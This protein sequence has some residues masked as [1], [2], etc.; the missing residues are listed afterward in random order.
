MNFDEAY[1]Q[2]LDACLEEFNER[3]GQSRKYHQESDIPKNY[4]PGDFVEFGEDG[5]AYPHGIGGTN[6]IP[7]VVT[8]WE[9]FAD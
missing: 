5:T 3:Y 6:Y 1:E 7:D 9:D 4:D 2:W 8:P